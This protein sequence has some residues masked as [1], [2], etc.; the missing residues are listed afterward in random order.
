MK[1]ERLLVLGCVVISV[2]FISCSKGDTG[3]QGLKG[4]PG[5]SVKGEPGQNGDSAYEIAVA[6]GFEGT[7]NEWLESL[8]GEKGNDGNDG[9]DGNANVKRFD[10]DMS[11][12]AGPTY[13]NTL[14]IAPQDLPDYTIFFYL[15]QSN[16]ILIPVPGS[17][18][19]DLYYSRIEYNEDTAEFTLKF[20]QT[21]TNTPYNVTI[22]KFTI[23]RIVAIKTPLTSKNG[24]ENLISQLKADGIDTNDYHAVA[25]YFGI[26]E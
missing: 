12:F 13:T 15:K 4:D 20:Y 5:E 22:G 9:Q 7:Q 2:T 6:E 19:A 14:A 18:E 24:N 11:D 8:N 17:L 10:I 23:F 16:G 26:E 25:K 21:S 1:L 3:E